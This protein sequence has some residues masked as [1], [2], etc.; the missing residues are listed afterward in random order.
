MRKDWKANPVIKARFENA[1]VDI[2]VDKS[3]REILEEGGVDC[4]DIGAVIWSHWHF[5]HTGNVPEFEKSTSL[6]VGQ[7]FK[8]KVL[9][10]YPT[11]AESYILESDWEGRELI[12]LDFSSS[13]L[14][15]GK[16]DAID[17][18]DDGSFY[19]LN[20]PG[21]AIG[22]ICALARV[23]ADPPSFILM[24]GDAYHHGGMLR[25][26]A[27]M[28]LPDSISPH[29]FT[30]NSSS[31]CPGHILEPLLR[32]GHKT[33][34]FYEPAPDKV[35][36]D[37]PEA[38]R[39]IQKLQEADVRDDILMVAAHDETM[40][41]VVDFFPKQANNFMKKGWVRQARWKFLMDFAKAVGYE[42]KL[43]GKRDWDPPRRS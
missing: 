10:G 16:M 24:G 2:R 9:P 28:P 13:G 29:P 38:I 8:E 19:F 34:P 5:D 11:N 7:G 20:T 40:L 14:K 15:I 32:G 27:Y 3:V 22:H 35:Y 23:T 30:S 26:S 25:P 31:P 1:N 36:H 4:N 12:E 21:H 41:D 43:D 39:T 42:G 18:F 37:V 6:I 17:Y 33:K